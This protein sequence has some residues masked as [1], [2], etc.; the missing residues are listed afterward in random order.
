MVGGI[1]LTHGHIASAI[2]D[3]A[4]TIIGKTEKIFTLSTS[5]YSLRSL[6]EELE[7]II[8]NE[9]FEQGVII[10]ASLKGGTCWNAAVAIAKKFPSKVEVVSGVNLN[11]FISYVTKRE[12]FALKNLAE[13][14]HDDA[15]RGI[16]RFD[17]N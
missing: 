1:V 2:V 12:Q 10:M 11:M 4:G 3:A 13:I 15:I 9:K 16:D 17:V 6:V 5:N 8:S 14:I 7:M